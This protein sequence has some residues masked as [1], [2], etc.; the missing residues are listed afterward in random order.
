[1][2]VLIR[3]AML[4]ASDLYGEGRENN[5]KGCPSRHPFLFICHSEERKR[6]KNPLMSCSRH[7]YNHQGILRFAQNDG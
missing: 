6:R 3:Q 5:A 7:L 1:M 4:L 2:P